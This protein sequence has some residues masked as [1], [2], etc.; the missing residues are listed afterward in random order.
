MIVCIV[1]IVEE[2][3]LLQSLTKSV[4]SF[5]S[6]REATSDAKKFPRKK[7]PCQFYRWVV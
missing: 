5:F 4:P 1:Y 6:V 3:G 7:G 2:L